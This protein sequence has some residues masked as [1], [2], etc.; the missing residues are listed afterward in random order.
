[1]MSIDV[2]ITILRHTAILSKIGFGLDS[3]QRVPQSRTQVGRKATINR[4]NKRNQLEL[5]WRSVG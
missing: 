2:R 4:I 1:M 5:N 3:R